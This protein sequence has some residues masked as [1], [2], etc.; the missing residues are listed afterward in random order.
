[1]R[2]WYSYHIRQVSGKC[3]SDLFITA[4]NV[5][6]DFHLLQKHIKNNVI[7]L[8]FRKLRFDDKR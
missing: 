4:K 8:V 2:E 6:S 1:M 3:I 5:Y 7:L